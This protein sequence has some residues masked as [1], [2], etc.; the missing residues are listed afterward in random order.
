[1]FNFFDE[2]KNNFAAEP[3]T[4]QNYQLINI[5]GKIVYVE[6]HLG[7]TQLSKDI[8]TFKVKGGR[9]TIEGENLNLAELTSNTLKICGKIVRIEVL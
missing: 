2:I 8:I 5:S 7:L 4:L 1:M 6:G 9:I 3:D